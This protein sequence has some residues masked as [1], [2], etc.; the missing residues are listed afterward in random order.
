[1]TV[2]T[3]W[4][5]GLVS[6]SREKQPDSTF[7]LSVPV[8]EALPG[9]IKQGINCLESQGQNTAG[10]LLLGMGICRGSAKS[11]PPA[12]VSYLGLTTGWNLRALAR[13]GVRASLC[14]F[15]SS[16]S[17]L[18]INLRPRALHIL[19]LPNAHSFPAL[20]PSLSLLKEEVLPGSM[21]EYSLDVWDGVQVSKTL[22]S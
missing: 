14:S 3:L 10:D 20:S 8:K 12:Q 17:T 21:L 19:L 16:R 4:R 2:A 7:L 18:S 9:V 15:F 6:K 11:P 5:K 13:S 22:H 1:M